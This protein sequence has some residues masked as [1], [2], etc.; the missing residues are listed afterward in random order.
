[1]NQKVEKKADKLYLVGKRVVTQLNETGSTVEELA[2]TT[3]LSLS[4]IKG[5]IHYNNP[6]KMLVAESIAEYLGLN[7][8]YILD[9][10]CS[11]KL[12]DVD[13]D[14]YSKAVM[15]TTQTMKKENIASSHNFLDS[16]AKMVYQNTKKR[17]Y[18]SEDKI[19]TFLEG[20][21]ETT[22]KYG[23]ISRKPSKD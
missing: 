5:Y 20:A 16:L 10:K 2:R 4:S 17:N 8:Q 15:L 11:K 13:Y 23:A 3:G 7:V 14:A 22:L 19:I 18:T 12:E 6:I 9:E 1:M 21:L